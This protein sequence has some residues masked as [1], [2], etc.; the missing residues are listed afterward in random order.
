[1]R[2]CPH[3]SIVALGTLDVE[4]SSHLG[5]ASGDGASRGPEHLGECGIA[6]PAAFYRRSCICEPAAS[7][8]KAQA[9]E[10]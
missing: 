9:L 6:L 7:S 2:L 3:R 10:Y 1:M 4:K 8:H 5:D